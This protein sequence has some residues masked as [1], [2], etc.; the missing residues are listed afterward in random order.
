MVGVPGGGQCGPEYL[1]VH[2]RLGWDWDFSVGEVAGVG[3]GGGGPWY[4]TDA[5]VNTVMSGA[6]VV[7]GQP[8]TGLSGGLSVSCKYSPHISTS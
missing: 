8:T 4:F 2:P 3:I 7:S 5:L 1:L 6:V